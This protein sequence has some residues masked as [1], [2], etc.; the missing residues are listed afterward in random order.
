[1]NFGFWRPKFRLLS[2]AGLV[3]LPL[4][5][6]SR[7]RSCKWGL[8][9]IERLRIGLVLGHLLAVGADEDVLAAVVCVGALDVGQV[10]I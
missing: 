3:P 4:C 10:L 8:T 7:H 1:M 9:L 5:D 2:E 6:W